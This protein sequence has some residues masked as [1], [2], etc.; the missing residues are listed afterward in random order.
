MLSQADKRNKKSGSFGVEELNMWCSP[1]NI[2]AQK[3]VFIFDACHSGKI[4]N[5]ISD[6]IN[7]GEYDADRIRQLDKLK[8]KNGM[9]ILA[10][11][12]E[13]QFAYEDPSLDQGVLTYHLLQAVKQQKG[14][15]LLIIKNWFDEAIRMVEE[16]CINNNSRQEPQ[17]F[18]DGRF[19]IGIINQKVRVS[20]VI[21]EP[22]VRVGTCIFTDPSGEAEKA[23]P[24][25]EQQIS[26]AFST[27]AGR[28]NWVNSQSDEN[29]YH[30]VGTYLL[31]G[32]KLIFRY[33]IY[34]GKTQIGEAI[35]LS[36]P[37]RQQETELVKI[38]T[39]SI[40][41]EVQKKS[42]KP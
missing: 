9:M 3:R 8:D 7:R 14:D 24:R 21:S 40:Y 19:Y 10:A 18:G 42:Q 17:N 32:K 33:R 34:Y 2:R 5:E 12:A 20:I 11:S 38:L 29:A 36:L 1:R 13:N 4:I 25:L 22:K 16:Y 6:K 15:S 28:G 27:K 37:S 41:T 35:S 30:V 26:K 23:Y 39:E 31:S